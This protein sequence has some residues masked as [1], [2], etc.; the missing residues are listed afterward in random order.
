[1]K[2]TLALLFCV[3]TPI[4]AQ[5]GT[6]PKLGPVEVHAVHYD[7][8][9]SNEA[10]Q[11][12][13]KLT[14]ECTNRVAT[15]LPLFEGE[16]AVVNPN[17]PEGLRLA[18]LAKGYQIIVEKAGRYEVQL[19]LLARITE[20]A[21]WHSVTFSGPAATIGKIT[22]QAEGDG[23]EL[24]LLSGTPLPRTGN[25][26]S[27]VRG[28]LGKDR[29]VNLRWQ[30]RVTRQE[31]RALLI[32]NTTSTIHINPTEARYHTTLAYD[33]LQGT[34]T[35]LTVR[36]PKEQSITKIE[37]QNIRDWRVTTVEEDQTLT[38]DFVQ[39]QP[40]AYTLA[41][42]SEQAITQTANLF[43]PEPQ[44]VEREGGRV[45]ITA[46]DVTVETGTVQG[47]RQANVAQG[48][49]GAW[50]Y[51]GRK[52]F[53]LPITTQRIKPRVNLTSTVSAN[54]GETRLLATHHLTL[55]VEKAGIY[56]LTLN[57]SQLTGD[58]AFTVS[59][60]ASNGLMDWKLDPD[61]GQI[62]LLYTS[63]VLGAQPVQ[64]V[65]EKP[66]GEFPGTFTV[67]PLRLGATEKEPFDLGRESATVN[68]RGARG[69]QLKAT[70]NQQTRE[71]AGGQA[72]LAFAS[73]QADW[74]VTFGVEK[75]DAQIIAEVF[76]LVTV[77]D[78]LLGGSATIRFGILNQ[79]VQ[80]FQVRIPSTNQWKNVLF[81][82]SNIR[83]TES[84]YN[85]EAKAMDWT[86]RLQEKVWNGYTLVVSYDNQ[87]EHDQATLQLG[88]AHPLGVKR[89]TGFLALTGASNL[90]LNPQY[91][92][93][94]LNRIDPSDLSEAD[95][96]LVN[97]PI[98]YAFKYEGDEF[99]LPVELQLYQE[100]NGLSAVADRT[101]IS[102][103]ITPEGELTTTATYMLKNNGKQHLLFTLP[104][105]FANVATSINDISVK[106]QKSG[107][108][109][110][111]PIP[112]GLDRN[113]AMRVKISYSQK[114]DP[115][116]KDTYL[117]GLQP[118]P[119]KLTAP[120][121]DV[122]NTYNE[123]TVHV[124]DEAFE[125]YDFD[126]NMVISGQNRYHWADG[127]HAFCRILN[128]TNWDACIALF[129]LF[130]T[131]FAILQLILRRGIR[132]WP[133][134]TGIGVLALIISV[135]I[136]GSIQSKDG[137]IRVL[138]AA[139]WSEDTAMAALEEAEYY[140]GA[141][142]KSA[143]E[144]GGDIPSPEPTAAPVVP[145]ESLKP[146]KAPA[147]NSGITRPTQSGQN[148]TTDQTLGGIKPAG[149]GASVSGGIPGGF[150]SDNNFP[151]RSNSAE[152]IGVRPVQLSE[153]R[154]GR[155][156]TFTKVL[157][158][159]EDTL[160][161]EALAMNHE[162]RMV[163]KGFFTLLLGLGGLWLLW[164][165]Y[166]AKERNTAAITL[167]MAVVYSALI[168]FS[169]DQQALHQLWI[170]TLWALILAITSW[171][172]WF[173]W[174]PRRPASA[175]PA[176]TTEESA[177]HE[178]GPDTGNGSG[179]ATAALLLGLFLSLE[180]HAQPAASATLTPDQIR[181][182]LI[183]LLNPQTDAPRTISEAALQDRNGIRYE[184]NQAEPFTGVVTGQ[185][186]NKQRRIESHYNQGKLHGT[187]TVWF[188]NG[189]KQSLT[190]YQNGQPHGNQTVW[191]RNGKTQSVTPYQ[192]G[193][194]HGTHKE[195]DDKGKL[196]TETPYQNGELHGLARAWHANGKLARAVRW[197]AG[198][199]LSF[200]TWDDKGVPGDDPLGRITIVS[201]DY[202]L[203]LHTQVAVVK[204]TYQ[205]AS[206]EPKQQI[207]L[208]TEQL[209]ID[210]FTCS[211][212]GAQL[213]REGPALVLHLPAAGKAEVQVSFLI[214]LK[215][216]ATARSLTF[217][218]PAA[219]T[220]EVKATLAEANAEIGVTG[221]V[222]TET[223]ANANQ[224]A[225]TALLG[226][227]AQLALQWKPRVKKA[228]EITATVFARS[229][230]L[231]T[232]QRGL[233]R[234]RTQ[235]DYQITQGEL[236]T[237]RI[238]LPAGH[239]LM[240]VQAEGV[241]TLE[242]TDGQ[243]ILNIAL[244]KPAGQAFQAVVELE[245]T[246]PAPPVAQAVTLPRVLEVKREQGLVALQS[247]DDLSVTAAQMTGLTK[248]NL[249]E[250]S[251]V[252]KL[253]GQTA[254]VYSY[255]NQF[256]LSTQ[257]EAVQPQLEAVAAHH[258]LVGS[259][260]HRLSSTINYTI[261]KTGLF[262]L[263]VAI[264]E[265]WEIEKVHGAHLSQTN[266]VEG[267]LELQ[268]AQRILGHYALRVD[269]QRRQPLAESIPVSAV[270][271]LGMQ[272]L[273]GYLAIGA[274]AG[275]ELK[276]T[277]VQ[278]ITEIPANELPS[279]IPNAPIVAF[280]PVYVTLPANVLAFKHT[281]PMPTDTLGW[282]LNV[283]PEELD[284][285]VRAEIVNRV[286]LHETHVEGQSTI[287]YQIGNAPT[288]TFRVRVP[289]EF[290]NVKFNGQGLR[291]DEPDPQSPND[292]IIT[293]Q[294]KRIG[295]YAL[296]FTWEW[297]GWS[298]NQTNTFNFRG[299]QVQGTQ[300]LDD[301]L[302]KVDPTVEL[303]SGW[304]A[305]YVTQTTPLQVQHGDLDKNLA[306]IDAADLPDHAQQTMAKPPTLTYR[307]MRPGY[308][309]PL[310]IQK[311]DDAAVL[312]T[313]I[314][315]AQ[316][317]S[318]VSE[319][320]QMITQARL[321]VKNNGRQFME[322]DLPNHTDEMWSAFVAG[323]AVRP[324]K[325]KNTYL[326]PLD[327]SEN[328]APFQ[329]EFTYASRFEFPK[330]QG[331]VEL[332]TPQ[333]NVPMQD[334]QWQLYLPDDYRYHDFKG[335]MTRT[336]QL[337][338]QHE[339]HRGYQQ[340][341]PALTPQSGDNAR[342]EDSTYALQEEAKVEKE[343]QLFDN[344]IFNA[345][346]N[347]KTGNLEQANRFLN[348]ALQLNNN[349]AP[350]TAKY[351]DLEQQIR[352]GQAKRQID[353]QFEYYSRNTQNAS[354][355]GGQQTTGQAV[356][357]TIDYDQDTAERQV[358]LV[359]KAQ[360]LTERRITPLRLN[361]PLRGRHY[362]F[363]QAS[364]METRKSMTVKFEARNTR[365]PEWNWILGGGV[366]GLV[367]LTGLV[368]LS[369]RALRRRCCQNTETA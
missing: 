140:E 208:F 138:Q 241:W 44:G 4:L 318:V 58:D 157:S 209:P 322:L 202:N 149:G 335:S 8:K 110:R 180:T 188:D 5:E 309:L 283:S 151:G 279:R 94:Q 46:E 36:L 96:G 262:K 288:R 155:S 239:K 122:P 34:P 349:D 7:A 226:T 234:T 14:L 363:A 216:N 97:R 237:A 144:D 173:F 268:L 174:P 187:Q 261:K 19:E 290:K 364:Q 147:Q 203:T 329:L 69:L 68:A 343:Q 166:R 186:A 123:W 193:K 121:S 62:T 351:R 347:F 78:G 336:R 289:E 52:P 112:G 33:I 104:D 182:T 367:A 331:A 263:A 198:R 165:Q 51:F 190:P 275:L 270:H 66:A 315:S 80:E 37:G 307:Y 60:V 213:R 229:T 108:Q 316:F 111:L 200:D 54:Q 40:K 181:Q 158:R 126:G 26:R 50:Q 156:F 154:Q 207:T 93:T 258:F 88:G 298:L 337:R 114:T 83:K 281:S 353:A 35:N 84:T 277:D 45:V 28:A 348:Q 232:F 106:P 127:W 249:D 254:G 345:E 330:S 256:T 143:R 294:D 244:T 99:E 3:V 304:L 59:N 23:T 133:W 211:Q 71:I 32:A 341:T 129:G 161:I 57:S 227:A 79:G 43:P 169:F 39:P 266:L 38:I 95:R 313:L 67:Q 179:A 175:P 235:V 87:F 145:N 61:S 300:L 224:T 317:T 276:A 22:A 306:A 15:P 167:G 10:A 191:H 128:R 302:P 217:G 92:Q 13:A 168:L 199:Q 194:R 246:L 323:R 278:G 310:A 185:Y 296:S 64:V 346:A 115:L 25:D 153:A 160:S 233:M 178:T 334:A 299:P 150:G 305:V 332:Q 113:R 192:N 286:F 338:E 252:M 201:A 139:D 21:P 293:L 308:A 105:G 284:P 273:T 269:L 360:R 272:K 327:Q 253:T 350:N 197:E 219:L 356:T 245:R 120:V 362:V 339:R 247:G 325:N 274:E 291:S 220:S 303:E 42:H 171:I 109:L 320:G 131:L 30:S 142:E 250:F 344:N 295:N 65:L 75:L 301:R 102:T 132:A 130:G 29:S 361:L 135:V 196:R 354:A 48:Q 55:Q 116:R 183:Q 74:S 280:N 6:P 100:E 118:V 357:G 53:V 27:T 267:R 342:Y 85:A 12:T 206:L 260:Q 264:P 20:T 328:G 72:V 221:A 164:T 359:Q 103:Q 236:R 365:E 243:S 107:E 31:R 255:L 248:R 352:R 251:R 231:V 16:L 73:T 292:W 90:K 18:R 312:Q 163:R 369:R 215:G 195:W 177:D 242:D 124:G 49:V 257:V 56:S 223:E 172:V 366:I 76:N 119:L 136:A 89:E 259:E 218:I 70:E 228:E 319:D 98:L 184:V 265:G 333:F 176:D 47:L 152:A 238:A 324:T 1:M 86:I 91:A 210:Q 240:R 159:E 77:G 82:G 311:F 297:D 225:I 41:I 170:G 321:D 134:L 271:P 282:S 287:Q 326:L 81:V 141:D 117:A 148:S 358:D 222:T 17:L 285:W 230:S 162:Q 63:R 214:P 189:Q 125:L 205:L 314:V 212:E 340:N 355:S 2:K 368:T 101:Q 9:L 204:A 11:F 24:E 146:K 137:S